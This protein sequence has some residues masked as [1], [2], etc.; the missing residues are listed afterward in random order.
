MDDDLHVHGEKMHVRPLPHS[1]L[2]YRSPGSIM[3]C[4]QAMNLINEA[5]SHN[6]EPEELHRLLIGQGTK[7]QLP[8][9]YFAAA[10]TLRAMFRAAEADAA[11]KAEYDAKVARLPSNAVIPA[12]VLS[13]AISQA[14]LVA[15]MK[16]QHLTLLKVQ[17]ELLSGSRQAV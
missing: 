9:S 10:G 1:L 3:L 14:R 2:T 7:S 17:H 12:P 6:M 11:A 16:T 15:C 4:P 8:R 13:G 5:L